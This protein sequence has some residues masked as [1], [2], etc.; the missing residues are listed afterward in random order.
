[1]QRGGSGERARAVRLMAFDV[2]G[3]LTDG[4][5]FVSASGEELKAFNILDGHGLRMLR[6]SGVQLALASGRASAALE[7]RARE[8]G[9]D[10]V[11]Q[12][13]TEKLP[14]FEALCARIGVALDA[15]GYMG[16]DLP[17]LPVLLRCG[18]A[19]SVPDAPE[20]VRNRVHYVT[21]AA[22]GR[23]AVREVCELVLA[24]QGNLD[25]ALRRYLS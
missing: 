25:A 14:A 4:T 5:V 3:V 1:M 10:H 20:A 12:G 2:D 16:D 8:L 22:G 24:A 11:L 23:G 6:E 17:D 15:C 13:L 9:I 18:F 19:A 21:R 7:R